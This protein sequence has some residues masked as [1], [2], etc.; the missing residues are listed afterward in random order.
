MRWHA[1]FRSAPALLPRL[2]QGALA[3]VA[4]L[5]CAFWISICAAAPEF[6]WQGLNLA[7]GHITRVDMLAA[8]LIGLVLAF[9]IEPVMERVRDLLSISQHRHPAERRPHDVLFTAC[10]SLVFALTSICLHE[11]M[12]AFVAN[13][14]AQAAGHDPGLSA[15]IVLTISWAIV[16]FAVTIAWLAVRVR[17][18]AIVTGI[19]AGASSYIT[20]WLFA[21]P[22]ETVIA[23]TIPCVIILGLGYRH[24]VRM[25]GPQVFARCARSVALVGTIWLI[26]ALLFDMAMPQFQLEQFELYDAPSFWM[27]VR[28]YIGW[29]IGLALAPSPFADRE[30]TPHGQAEAR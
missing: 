12:T 9:F 2:L 23:T 15:G 19:I 7:L 8:L 3:G 18:L 30:Q 26:A 11:A 5:I 13:R 16:P 1:L 28:F 29:T 20:A 21:W 22:V 14:D 25:P 24:M 27:D 17:W 6:I 4:A 10:L